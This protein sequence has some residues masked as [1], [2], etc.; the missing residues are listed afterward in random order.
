M[1]GGRRAC[2]GSRG[3]SSG[4]SC[5][6][7]RCSSVRRRGT[8][9]QRRHWPR[10]SP[11]LRESGSSDPRGSARLTGRFHVKPARGASRPGSWLIRTFVHGVTRAPCRAPTRTGDGGHDRCRGRCRPLARPV[12]GRN[13]GV[14]AGGR[15]PY[16][17]PTCVWSSHM[18]PCGK[19]S[20]TV[21]STE[22]ELR[23]HHEHFG[24]V[25]LTP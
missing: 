15:P 19:L 11:I 12:M 17:I 6:C 3:S 16:C 9:W 7:Q 20:G 24:D 10:G 22:E 1:G 5:C 2:P 4:G 14:D 18:R 25:R 23:R 21:A 13:G 8:L